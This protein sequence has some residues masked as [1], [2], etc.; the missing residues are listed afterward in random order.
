VLVDEVEFVWI[1]E[2]EFEFN[3]RFGF[4]FVYEVCLGLCLKL[5]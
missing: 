4:V 5:S 3:I 2:F 1:V